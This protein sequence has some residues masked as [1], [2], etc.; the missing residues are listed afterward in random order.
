[1]SSTPLVQSHDQTTA[2][3]QSRPSLVDCAKKLAPALRERAAE[4]NRLR[5]LP[6]STW[7][8]LIETGI[9]RGLQPA[10]W[11]GGEVHPREFY[12]AI[13]EVARAE[14]CAGWV[15]GIV[16][17]HPWHVALFPKQTQEEVWG[18]DPTAMNSSS[19]APTGK[20]ERVP[21]GLRLSGRWSFSSGCDHCKWVVLG[22]VVG[23]VEI[24]GQQYPD[25]HSFLLPRKDY[26]IDDNWHVAGLAGTGSKDIVVDGALV[27]EHR[28]QSH[29]EYTMGRPLPGWE[30]NPAPLYRL[31]FAVVFI[32]TLTAA[33]LGATAGFM[34]TWLEIGRTRV[35]G[36]G[37]VVSKDP[38]SLKLAAEAGYTIKSASLKFLHDCD[39]MMDA[40][41]AGET[42]T[43]ER[44]AE[45]RYNTV[46]SAQLAARAVERLFEAGGGHSIFLDHP[47][48]RRYQDIKAMMAHAA[49]NPNPAAKLYG[50]AQ[51]G[52]PVFDLFL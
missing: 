30:I 33:I 22:A 52:V 11:G 14:G 38:Y 10:R 50:A 8:D 15:A 43:Q 17:V 42:L 12:T 48:Q 1:M 29:W 19:Y 49:M 35:G 26:R 36:L 41:G 13:G 24:K 20:A 34:D 6:D 16:G 40:A 47:L 31:P 25:L 23:T 18:E 7:N 21:G 45:L 51:L 28:S 9:L 37:L 39:E 4:T 3:I 27:P 46:R 32:N 5:R 44:R 2:T